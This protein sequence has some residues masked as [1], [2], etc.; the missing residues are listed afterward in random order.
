MII[1]RLVNQAPGVPVPEQARPSAAPWWS[2]W[3]LGGGFSGRTRLGKSVD[4]D[5]AKRIA[6]AF[7]CGNILSDDVAGMPLQV[8]NSYRG[9]IRRI[10]PDAVARNTAY[11]VEKQPNRWMT[12]FIFKKTVMNWLIWWGDAYIW[13]P[14]SAYR[15][16]W[17]LPSNSTKPAFDEGGNLWYSTTFPNREEELIPDAEIVHLMINSRDGITGRSVL[18]YARETFGRQLG[19]HETQD[20]LASNSLNPTAAITVASETTPESRKVIKS[21]YLEASQGGVVVL[22]NKV[23]KFDT[24]TMK[25]VDAQFLEGM[26]LTDSE[27]ANFFGIPL[28]K[29]NQGKQS[30]ESNEQQ[31]LDYLKSTLNPYLVQQEQ[32]GNLKWFSEADQPFTYLKYNRDSIL[33]TSAKTRGE[34]LER[35]ILSGQMSPNEARGVDDMNPYPGGDSYYIPANTGKILPDG[36]VQVGGGNGTSTGN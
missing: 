15:E 34:I 9:T 16:M 29:V 6:T 26:Q 7:R 36:S 11:L 18:T 31:D 14:P 3:D 12:P 10:Y 23:T 2:R 20:N 25:P 4:E 30:Y 17:I 22:D 32:G 35:K 24:I 33:Q 19:A 28:Y 8:F 21:S 1:G 5:K 27:I 13:T